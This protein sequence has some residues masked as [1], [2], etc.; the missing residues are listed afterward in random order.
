MNSF[1]QYA[2]QVSCTRKGDDSPNE[3]APECQTVTSTQWKTITQTE[4]SVVTN[5]RVVPSL[6]IVPTT[7]NKPTTI[8]HT[9]I[10]TVWKPTTAI[11]T[12]VFTTTYPTTNI[13]EHNQA[14]TIIKT[15]YKTLEE[16]ITTQY[17][18][19]TIVESV[20]HQVSAPP[21]PTA[22]PVAPP[23]ATFTVTPGFTVSLCPSP[24]GSH[25]PLPTGSDLTFG[26]KPGYVCNPPKETNCN[27][28]PGPPSDDFL[29]SPCDCMIAPPFH[30]VTWNPTETSYYP[31]S[32]GYFNLDP[33]PFGL[34][35]DIFAFN[36]YTDVVDNCTLTRTTGNWAPQATLSEWPH[37]Q[38]TTSC[39]CTKDIHDHSKRS[40]QKRDLTP[41]I[42]YDDCN[43]AYLIAGA[44]GKTDDLC[45]FGSPFLQA[46][47]SCATCIGDNSAGKNPIDD[48]VNPVFEQY[49]NFCKGKSST[50]MSTG[51][52]P[53]PAMP[54]M[55]PVETTNQQAVSSTG[56]TLVQ[57][58][59]SSV[60]EGSPSSTP[61][62]TPAGAT[63]APVPITTTT[64]ASIGVT[65]PATQ[66]S[67][68]DQSP[69]SSALTPVVK[70]PVGTTVDQNN[71][72]STYT[73]SSTMN[74]TDSPDDNSTS[75]SPGNSGQNSANSVTN[76]T[77]SGSALTQSSPGQPSGTDHSSPSQTPEASNPGTSVPP[78]PQSSDS[79]SP[80]GT[81][82]NPN[83]TAIT[84]GATTPKGS[85]FLA[86]AAAVAILL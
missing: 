21:P 42:C 83:S 20:T 76:P 11:K 41:A 4:S 80:I 64:V 54:L 77:A 30:N 18:A 47:N 56:F 10:K 48:Y 7:V 78:N 14:D 26:C 1:N 36:T 43:N 49:F 65:V 51:N 32:Y 69:S 44:V 19:S 74:P 63:T 70:S 85:T 3:N 75:A 59:P 84:A 72:Q 73:A 71:G 40:M 81:Q 53:D 66:E 58:I 38:S 25:R 17:P 16:T 27:L 6:S 55:P 34:S 86:A 22:A 13:N 62:S 28:F 5:T 24:T 9:I 37:K 12:T 8:D 50:P 23:Q 2:H 39:G 46:Y 57:P 45:K 15:Q 79:V 35:Y 33:E 82:T 52:S 31:P 68:P 29:C 61:A 67:E 60:A